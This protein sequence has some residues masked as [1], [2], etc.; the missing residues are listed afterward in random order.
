MPSPTR[1]DQA[2][3][4]YQN[5]KGYLAELNARVRVRARLYGENALQVTVDDGG[6]SPV[7]I[8]RL[9]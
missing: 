6:L 7:D 9:H 8:Q 5:I 3:R 2:G 4:T 1:F